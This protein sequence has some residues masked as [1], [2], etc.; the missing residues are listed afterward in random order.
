[1]LGESRIQLFSARAGGGV[2]GHFT[3]CGLRE[4]AIGRRIAAAIGG[5]RQVRFPGPHGLVHG[6][7]LTS[8]R[9][10]EIDALLAAITRRALARMYTTVFFAGDR[11]TAALLRAAGVGAPADLA[12]ISPLVIGAYEPGRAE[13]LARV[14]AAAPARRARSA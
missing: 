7:A 8:A 12:R 13:H 9:P 3:L 4:H 10:D 1:M 14:R 2:L 5:P 6:V 11:A